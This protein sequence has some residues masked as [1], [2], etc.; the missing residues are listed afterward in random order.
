M[1]A[2][3]KISDNSWLALKRR[4]GRQGGFEEFSFEISGAG[5]STR[6]P[7]RCW[8][9]VRSNKCELLSITTSLENA[10]G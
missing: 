7:G 4:R 9:V 10:G 5:L 6:S 3:A 1:Q 2:G 8:V